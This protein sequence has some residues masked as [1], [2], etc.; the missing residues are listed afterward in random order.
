MIKK[1]C[2]IFDTKSEA[3]FTP[4]FFQSIG[5]EMR[6]FSDA[7]NDLS[8][9]FGKHPEDYVLFELGEFGERDGIIHAL[10]APKSLAVG[11]NLVTQDNQ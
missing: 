2:S 3:W 10:D 5:Q 4:I 9:D 11:V 1:I 8:T 7:V 6:S